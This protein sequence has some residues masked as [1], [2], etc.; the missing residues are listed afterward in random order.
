MYDAVVARLTPQQHVSLF[1]CWHHR[2]GDWWGTSNP[3]KSYNDPA[4]LMDTYTP[5]AKK[6]FTYPSLE[7]RIEN[8]A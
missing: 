2:C 3:L 7:A 8:A 4:G 1:G 6:F 5:G